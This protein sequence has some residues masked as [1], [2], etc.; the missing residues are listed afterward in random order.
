MKVLLLDDDKQLRLNLSAYLEDEGYTV[1]N[2]E[3]AEEALQII[4]RDKYKV[5]I[6]DI[7]LPGIDGEEFINIASGK[8][9]GTRYLIHTGIY[10]YQLSKEMK[11]LGISEDD[12]IYKPVIDM[13]FLVE[14]VKA[15]FES[16]Q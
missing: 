3:S 14:K 11:S 12:L 5:A 16:K 4:N 10:D 15:I 8:T 13:N 6:V 7:N 1:V 9:P 2:A